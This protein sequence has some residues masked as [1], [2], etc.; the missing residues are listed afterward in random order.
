MSA[1][2]ANLRDHFRSRYT[3]ARVTAEVKLFDSDARPHLPMQLRD[4]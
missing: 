1:R 3:L 4:I 2:R